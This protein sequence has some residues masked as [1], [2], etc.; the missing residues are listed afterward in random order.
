MGHLPP[1]DTIL[2]LSAALAAATQSVQPYQARLHPGP[3][4]PRVEH[5]PQA[6]RKCKPMT[7][8]N[9]DS[10]NGKRL[11]P[12]KEVLRQL[13]LKSG[14]LCAFP[15]CN[16]PIMDQ[17]GRYVGQMC[18][19]EAAEPGGERFNENQTDEQ[20]RSFNNLLL[21]C[22]PHHVETND[23][24]AFPVK[25]MQEMKA[26]H[27]RKVF[28][29]IEN[30]QLRVIDTTKLTQTTPAVSLTQMS[31]LWAGRLTAEELAITVKEINKLL[32]RLK[33]LPRPARELLVLIVDK[34]PQS[35]SMRE[36]VAI[37]EIELSCGLKPQVLSKL[38]EMLYRYGFITEGG[39]DDFGHPRLSLNDIDS[40]W[41]V[42]HDFKKFAAT[43]YATLDELI[44]ELNFGLLDERRLET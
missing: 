44:V 11:A 36:F 18:H 7:T 6:D 33:R 12:T 34:A 9:D 37:H 32:A 28:N 2:E 14:N 35:G 4:D 1:Q 41:S 42:W 43:G 22:Y 29:F 38:L 40:Q 3:A 17:E 30:L 27:E 24:E 8:T 25:R 26:N 20:R 21:L 23:V 31:K 19:I 39:E 10:S 16:S 13:F 5:S 15:A